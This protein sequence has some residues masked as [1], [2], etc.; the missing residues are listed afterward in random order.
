M[1]KKRFYF[2]QDLILEKKR[3]LF[4]HFFSDFLAH[5]LNK[6]NFL[7]KRLSFARNKFL[8]KTS[9]KYVFFNKSFVTY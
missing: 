1:K 3:K 2:Q 8:L 6:K 9:L 4:Y 7:K 5:I